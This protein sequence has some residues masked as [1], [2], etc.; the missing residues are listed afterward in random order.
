MG[1]GCQFSSLRVGT[2]YA[3]T[4]SR[5]M[6]P[7]RVVGITRKS[8][9]LVPLTSFARPDARA[10]TS[11][12]KGDRRAG[13]P[14]QKKGAIRRRAQGATLEELARSYNVSRA[15]ISRLAPVSVT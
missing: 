6:E 10:E 14:A 12:A 1:S 2:A 8:V 11:T 3:E 5:T 13:R 9:L 7:T 4:A 15:T